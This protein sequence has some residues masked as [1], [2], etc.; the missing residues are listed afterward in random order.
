M[1]RRVRRRAVAP[2]AA[3]SQMSRPRLRFSRPRS[4]EGGGGERGATAKLL[5]E[6]RRNIASRDTI[7]SN[8]RLEL[9]SLRQAKQQAQEQIDAVSAEVAAIH[10][11]CETLSADVCLKERTIEDLQKRCGAAQSTAVKGSTTSGSID[12]GSGSGA[13]EVVEPGQ[14]PKEGRLQQRAADTAIG[15]LQQRLHPIEVRGLYLSRATGTETQQQTQWGKEEEGEEEEREGLRGELLRLR[16]CLDR[17]EEARGESG[18]LWRRRLEADLRTAESE[19]STARAEVEACKR[20][21]A[22]M[23]RQ[24]TAAGFM[25]AQLQAARNENDALQQRV[26]EL[27]EENLAQSA[28]ERE[29]LDELRATKEAYDRREDE[30]SSLQRRLRASREKEG[31][32]RE[33]V[34]TLEGRLRA[35]GPAAS[36]THHRNDGSGAVPA[37]APPPHELSSYAALMELNARLQ[38]R[39]ALL[40]AELQQARKAAPA[41]HAA[42][43]A[44]ATSDEGVGLVKER[45]TQLDKCVS[46]LQQRLAQTG[47]FLQQQQQQQAQFATSQ[48][49]CERMRTELNAVRDAYGALSDCWGA[50]IEELAGVGSSGAATAGED[51]HAGRQ[52]APLEGPRPSAIRSRL[53]DVQRHALLTAEDAPATIAALR[54]EVS[55]LSECLRQREEELGQT[56][57]ELVAAKLELDNVRRRAATCEGIGRGVGERKV[58]SLRAARMELEHWRQQAMERA[59][60]CETLN[61]QCEEQ[62]QL[63]TSLHASLRLNPTTPSLTSGLG[64]IVGADGN[65][66]RII[67]EALREETARLD[68]EMNALRRE[69]RTMRRERDHWKAVAAGTAPPAS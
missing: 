18:R 9:S 44:A 5:L 37:N 46:E 22:R 65:D 42:A 32:L 3:R 28:R 17:E 51:T 6:L 60:A 53:Q 34:E 1:N 4:A 56:R 69:V 14:R 12:N 38:Q 67:E 24:V 40:E 15:S 16:Q 7:I 21:V 23:Q 33:E 13:P 8:L 68:E 54:A 26:C 64:L 45:V 39:L 19:L 63:I 50:L 35:V 29:L 49:S 31:G 47:A 61:K 36:Y 2:G 41:A 48:L 58:S 25:E 43:V 59:L 30:V 55:R 10:A 20:E 52:A 66:D 27:R 57:R 62:Q 11:R